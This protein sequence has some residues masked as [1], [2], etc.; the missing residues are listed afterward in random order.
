M[1]IA[2]LVAGYSLGEADILRR[3]MGKKKREEMDAQ[4][5][6]FLAGARE[7]GIP[8][9]KAE[10]LFDLM[11]EFA[12]Y[13]FNKSH[14]AA[15]AY[16]AYVTAYLKAHYPIEF[17][18]ALL[19]SE[20]GNSGKVVKYINECR[21][22]GIRVLPPDVNAS[23]LNFTPDGEAIRFGLGAIKN[24][25][26]S[27]VEAILKARAAAGGRFRTLPEFCEKV[28]ISAI[29]RRMIESFIKA[30]AMDSLQGNRAQLFA[31]LDR[32]LES[33]QRA[34]RD[35]QSGQAGLFGF[36]ETEAAPEIPLP[37]VPDWTPKEK[38]AGEKE[39]IG[40]YVTG[41][42]LDEFSD[43]IPDLATHNTSNLEGLERNAEVRLCG[44]ITNIQ[45]RRNKE[46]RQWAMFQLED[47]YGQA[48]CM[49]FAAAYENLAKELADDQAVLVRGLALPE[50]NAAPRIS[51]K[52]IT[53][54]N[55][56]RVD[57]PRLISIRVLLNGK[58]DDR[59]AELTKLFERKQ[60]DA[61]VRLRLEKPRDF[62]LI[63]D[64]TSRVRPDK[65]FVAEVERI[66]GPQ[67]YEVLAGG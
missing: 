45:K 26:A 54:L 8:E 56:A 64:I 47:W 6:R 52:E 38:L 28:D 17:M 53:P 25:G 15:Y 5:V 39:T 30:G 62:S 67:S 61:E 49:V 63:M 31:I 4:R 33:G 41:H 57:L 59:A 20:T 13:G 43:R 22:M 46:G 2:S 24:V 29:N 19:T 27:A 50:E 12:N 36:M 48:E 34:L 21:D 11:A 23:E 40:F 32:S 51:V 37:D 9:K 14:S 55:L 60:G 35:R 58:G 1:Q 3:A 7:K 66:C 16:L 44:V 65:E 42:P 18:S 10:K